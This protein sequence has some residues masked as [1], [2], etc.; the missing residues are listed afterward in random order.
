MKPISLKEINSSERGASML[1]Y[2]LLA[3]LISVVAITGVASVGQQARTAFEDVGEAI[4]NTQIPT[5][6]NSI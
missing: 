3:A 6:P 1:E 4:G 2:A 5:N